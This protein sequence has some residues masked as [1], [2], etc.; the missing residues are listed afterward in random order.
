[1]SLP[2]S[3]YGDIRGY[4]ER[5]HNPPPK[6]PSSPSF[7][8]ASEQPPTQKP[9]PSGT[10]GDGPETFTDASS[11]TE[12]QPARPSADEASHLG[13]PPSAATTN[14]VNSESGDEDHDAISKN[15][16]ED[17]SLVA[18]SFASVTSNSEDLFQTSSQ[19]FLVGSRRIVKNGEVRIQDSDDESDSDNFLEDLDDLLGIRKPYDKGQLKK[20]D[21]VADQA[22]GVK[23]TYE[24][25]WLS[26][27]PQ[28]RR[29]RARANDQAATFEPERSDSHGQ[30][31]AQHTKR[32]RHKATKTRTS[33]HSDELAPPKKYKFS[34]DSLAKRRKQYEESNV[35]LAQAKLMLDTYD[36][37]KSRQDGQTKLSERGGNWNIEL[38]DTVMKEHGDE[39]GVGRLKIAI[40]RTEALQGT[41]SWS[42][43]EDCPNETPQDFPDFPIEAVD[44]RLRPVLG[45]RSSRQ[46]A[47]LT[48]HLEDLASREGLPDELVLWLTDASCAEIRDDLRLSYT[49]T[50]SVARNLPSLLT[51]QRIDELFARLGAKPE[52]LNVDDIVVPRI[53]ISEILDSAP[54]PNLLSILELFRSIAG[55]LQSGSRAH[56][57]YLLCRLSLDTSVAINVRTAR[58]SAD[59]FTVL[60]SSIPEDDW[61]IEVLILL[62]RIY[63]NIEDTTLRLQLLQSIPAAQPRLNILRRRLALA[64]FFQDN[65]LLNKRPSETVDLDIISQQLQES[66]F[67]ARNVT[68]WG[69]IAATIGILNVGINSGDPTSPRSANQDESDFNRQVD[70]LARSIKGI[71]TQIKDTGTSHMKKTEAKE[72]LEAFHS[73]LL[74][75]VRTKPPPKKLF[76]M[77]DP[78]AMKLEEIW[79]SREMSIN[80]ALM[81]PPN[82]L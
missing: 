68:N 40:Q 8:N 69:E 24:G 23:P 21:T 19:P 30:A 29:R 80:N 67:T 46:Q 72:T 52:A 79:K 2:S 65:R 4:F 16:M 42:F 39:D 56:L 12:E 13:Q 48:G 20:L 31:H 15:C 63:D 82:G 18:S 44:P 55:D 58:A 17:Y 64:F 5:F 47:F 57:L 77:G 78:Q 32:G 66:H 51:P 11:F 25:T 54:R 75:A 7:S 1:M 49:T 41:K 73:R 76:L 14:S 81:S 62:T 43:F 60:T 9:S 45:D 3:K 71:F 61:E 10:F 33:L 59:A 22:K 38:I 70:N 74:Y 6:K 37:E 53:A 35:G 28:D 36:Q 50:L 27:I 34:L 26:D